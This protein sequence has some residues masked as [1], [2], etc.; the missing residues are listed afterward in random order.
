MWDRDS[1]K[2][3]LAIETFDVPV[4]A[5]GTID[6]RRKDITG[7]ID[8]RPCGAITAPILTALYPHGNPSIGASLLGA[9]DT[10]TEVH[11]TAG[12]K[13][14]FHSTALTKM[15]P[16]KLST[17]ESAFSGAAEITALIKNNVTRITDN[18]L[19]TAASIAW[20][21]SFDVANVKGGTYLGTWGTAPGI[22]FQTA[23]GWDIDFEM[24]TQP[25]YCDG[26]G[27]YD[28]MLTA[29][30]VR[31]RCR[32]LGLSE[33]TLLG[34][35]NLQGTNCVLGGTMRS[36]LDLTIAATNALTV[37]IKDAA[38]VKG[39]MEW[40]STNLRI[41]EIGFIGHRYITGGTPGQLFSVALTA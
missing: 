26:V 35:L 18:S 38:L 32:P 31:A 13:V 39:P 30:T 25:Q 20:S 7:K 23:E 33:S 12:Q 34:Y 5:Y 22:V 6:T 2:A 24:Q 11:S 37:I 8:F 17:I 14:T 27:T 1:I 3:D 21:G 9:T 4:S 28:I 19:Y 41:G 36:G 29:V 10:A 40:G 16:L 15:P